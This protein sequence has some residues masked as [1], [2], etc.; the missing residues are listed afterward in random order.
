MRDPR[1][2]LKQGYIALI[3]GKVLL[4]GVV[5]PIYDT[6]VPDSAQAP[7]IIYSTVNIGPSRNV[8]SSNYGFTVAVLIDVVTAYFGGFGGTMDVLNLSDQI[9]N[10]V[11]PG[12]PRD[13]KPLSLL[14]NFK[15][16]VTT[17]LSDT[18][19]NS[20]NETKKVVRN[21]IRFEHIIEE[22]N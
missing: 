10:L 21:L 19:M 22:I 11:L 8:N 2:Q 6:V 15:L 4:N 18:E 14:P 1:N 5:V 3:T 12:K 16:I 17:V 9:K 7:Y 20:G 13:I